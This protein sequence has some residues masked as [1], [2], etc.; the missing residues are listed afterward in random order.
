MCAM[1]HSRLARGQPQQ[2]IHFPL[3]EPPESIG[4]S[5]MPN[6]NSSPASGSSPSGGGGGVALI[7]VNAAFEYAAIVILA[8]AIVYINQ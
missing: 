5:K 1:S 4:N 3:S 8:V 7:R 6:R 2:A